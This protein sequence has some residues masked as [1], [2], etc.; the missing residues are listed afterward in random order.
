MR[1]LIVVAVDEV[2]EFRLLLQE[3]VAGRLGGL[4]L[5]GQMHAFMAAILLRVAGL[6]AFDLDAEPEPPHRH[7]AQPEERIGACEGNAVVRADGLGETELL[8]DGLEHRE[9]IGFLGGGERLAGEEIAAGEVGD[10]QRIAIASVGE[11]LSSDPGIG[12]AEAFRRAMLSIIDDAGE[13]GSPANE[14]HPSYWA[15]FVVVGEGG[16]GR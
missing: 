3:V 16:A 4:Q 12:R 15:P 5:Q 14:A 7:L 6:D 2:V 10:R 11:P 1:P 9:G 8:E 13:Q